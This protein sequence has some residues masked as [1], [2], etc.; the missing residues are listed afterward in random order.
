VIWH[1][2]ALHVAPVAFAGKGWVQSVHVPPLLPQA[3][4]EFAVHGP[5]MD[6]QQPFGQDCAL[7]WH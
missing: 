6:P 1:A 5:V 2:P 3:V 4:G 7:H